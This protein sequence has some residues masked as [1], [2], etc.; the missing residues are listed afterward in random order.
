[1]RAPFRFVCVGSVRL[2]VDPLDVRFHNRIHVGQDSL[3]FCDFLAHLAPSRGRLLDVGTGSGVILLNEARRGSVDEAVG[4][5]INPRAVAIAALNARVNGVEA[6]IVEQDIFAASTDLGCFDR[7]TWNAPFR[8]LPETE[9]H[10]NVDGFGGRL[11]MGLTLD[12]LEVLPRL[13]TERGDALIMS[14][15]PRMRDGS[16]PFDEELEVAA[17]RTGMDIEAH[18]QGIFFDARRKAFLHAHGVK[19]F[20]SVMLRVH[21]GSGRYQRIRPGPG[22]SVSNALRRLVHVLRS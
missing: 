7:I 2:L 14:A 5:D 9:K 16:R 12:F 11:G 21:H 3:A 18:V 22:T 10:D 1:V 13:L 6:R 15:S 19:A 8:F 20:D 17:A 4:V